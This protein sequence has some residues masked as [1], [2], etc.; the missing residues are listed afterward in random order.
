MEFQVE[1]Q[2]RASTVLE[3][4]TKVGDLAQW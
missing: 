3:D 2:K 4:G 1:E